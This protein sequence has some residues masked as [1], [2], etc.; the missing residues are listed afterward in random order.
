MACLMFRSKPD[1][2]VP[3]E[4]SLVVELAKKAAEGLRRTMETKTTGGGAD[5]GIFLIRGLLSVRNRY[6]GYAYD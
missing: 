5:A 2:P 6:A 3:A 4:R 1:S